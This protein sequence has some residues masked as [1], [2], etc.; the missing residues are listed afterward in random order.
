MRSSITPV[1]TWIA[2]LWACSPP[3]AAQPS[4]GFSF[5]TEFARLSLDATGTVTALADKQSGTDRVDR[6]GGGKLAFAR[7]KGQS[8]PV[9]GL[10][11]DGDR[12]RLSFAG[13]D[14]SADLRLAAHGSYFVIELV[15]ASG[16]AD[17]IDLVQL[18]L[19]LK[20]D[21]SEPLA[22]CALAL[23]LRTN[24]HAL[25]QPVG[26]LQATAY[27][28]LGFAG[29]KVAIVLC[30]QARLRD[31]M[32]EVVAAA[33]ELPQTRIGGPWALDA[34]AN[35]GSYILE[36]TGSVGEA[37]IDR[38][39]RM[40]SELGISQLDF[41]CG[42]SF[43]FG[44]YTPHPEVY[45]RGVE[46]VR[47]VTDKLHAAGMLAGFHT[48]AFFIAKDSPFVTPV[49]NPGLAFDASYTLGEALAA[50]ATTVP[51]TESTSAAS[52]ITGFF[53]RNSATLRIGDEL[54]IYKGVR[55][56]PPFGFTECQRGAYGTKV[57]AHA[58]GAKVRHLKEC[59]GLFVPD[60]D[61]S[62]FIDVIERTAGMYN[63]G[64]FDMIYLDALDGSDIL[65]GG[66]WA[67]Y[68]GSRFVFELARRLRKPALFEMS[69]FHHHLW[70]V[71]SR[72][73]AW[74]CPSRAPK[75]FIEI[76]RIVNR[77]C[78]DM[79]LPAHLGWWA[80]FDWQGIQPER[81]TADVIEYLCT[82]CIADGCGMSFPVGFTPEAYENSPNTQRLGKIVRQYEDLRRSGA[83]PEDVRKRLGT[84]GEE[85]TLESVSPPRFR[86]VRYDHHKLM[87]VDAAGST[88]EVN[89]T[90]GA[91]PLRCRIEALLS[92]AAYDDPESV[93]I[94]DFSKPAAFDER[95]SSEGVMLRFDRLEN[96]DR[97]AVRLAGTRAGQDAKPAW[98][99]VGRKHAPLLNVANKG[100]GFW[101]KGDGRGEVLNIQLKSPVH[102]YG[103]SCDRYARIDFE[104]WKYV[105]LIEPE[106]E[107][108][109]R[110]GWPY[111]PLPAEW[112]KQ[113]G[114]L[115]G[116]AYP[117][118]HIQVMFDRIE[119]FN[120][121]YGDLPAGEVSCDISPIKAVPLRPCKLRNPALTVGDRTIT[122]PVELESG[123]YLEFVSPEDC[124]VYGPKGDLIAEVK[125]TGEVP[126]VSG[127][128]NRLG[129]AA[130]AVPGP[131]PRASVTL[132]T[133]G[134]PL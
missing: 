93:V 62:L 30:P 52:E 118:M 105:E 82:R 37:Q 31:V 51:V 4:G 120:L 1:V 40:L 9:T 117:N 41:H 36:C 70:Y 7:V 11:K 77:N 123:Q 66:E 48:Y 96:A 101:V 71:R 65:G 61:S 91:Q 85:F 104:G 5:E 108:M 59:F 72:M 126:T 80:I 124:K 63:E 86:P 78:R 54:I 99:M 28:K 74:D 27:A 131:H 12:L 19:T 2:C 110:H 42:R 29:A 102:A 76:H 10:V 18:P 33:D 35:Q 47:A 13:T 95:Q 67:W 32:K 55:K 23:N 68:H 109:I 34:P 50:D 89:N 53:V 45:P 116:Y 39:I 17:S 111:M 43:R 57:S 20:G 83:V 132:I 121:W 107:A 60:P 15:H 87:G 90:F 113:S 128:A 84:F 114:Q 6:S 92:A 16:S 119:S 115:M 75:P 103:G 94:E 106:G 26:R 127:G 122:F 97:A 81:T 88:W 112:G 100:L 44:D 125:P 134:D 22:A 129:F 98:A 46:S 24:V 58:A 79:F 38:W 69:T 133:R 49:P 73:G 14:V 25:P 21:P 8:H 56:E 64:G 3:V 130:D